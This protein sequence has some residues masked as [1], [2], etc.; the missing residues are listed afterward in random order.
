MSLRSTE[1]HWGI[2]S[3]FLHWVTLLLLL[4]TVP[5]GT[6]MDDLPTGANKVRL[7]ALH[8]SIGITILGLVVLRVLWRLADRRPLEVPMPMWQSRAARGLQLSLY[9]LL[10]AVPLA[11]WVMNSAS[12][13]PLRWFGLVN[14]PALTSA[15]KGVK[16]LFD[17]LHAW[18]AWTLV[19]LAA[20]HAVAALKHHFID[21]DAT[22]R[23]M[24]PLRFSRG[25]RP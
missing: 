7:F 14:L 6:F 18:A 22:L 21:K 8:K 24:L 19:V 4:V 12:G 10:F 16:A 5:I 20:G 13:F 15:D 11:G 25:S 9:V 3:R 23:A 2:A 17:D 1:T